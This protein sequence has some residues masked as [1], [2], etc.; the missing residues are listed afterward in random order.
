MLNR[1]IRLAAHHLVHHHCPRRI[2]Q[3][4]DLG[5]G[6]DQ[7]GLAKVLGGGASLA[8]YHLEAACDRILPLVR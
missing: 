6:A 7:T 5:V 4:T 8:L 1:Q 3:L 2:V